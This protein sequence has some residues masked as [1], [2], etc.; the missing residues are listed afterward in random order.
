MIYQGALYLH[1][2]PK[3]GTEDLLLFVVPK[4]H[5]VTAL[6]RCHRDA[7]HQGIDS[8]LSLLREGFQWPGMISQIQQ[9]IKNCI[10]CLQHEGNLSKAPLHLIVVNVPLDLLHVD[11]TSIEMTMELNL[12]PRIANVLVYVTPSQTAKMA[13]KFL[14]QGY[15]PVFRALARLLSNWGANFMSSIINE[16]CTL[17]SV[18]K[19]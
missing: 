14:Y 7:G 15:I 19:L 16:M 10:C 2:M 8:T 11:F 12:L 5:W 6:N 9:S 13:T 18:K 1:S 4:A 17:L 3:G